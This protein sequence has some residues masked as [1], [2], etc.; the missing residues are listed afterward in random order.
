MDQVEGGR[1][2]A[3]NYAPYFDE[4]QHSLWMGCGARAL[5][6]GGISVVALATG[7]SRSRVSDGVAQ[8]RAGVTPLGQAR[9]AG[10]GTVP[11]ACQASNRADTNTVCPLRVSN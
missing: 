11:S 8:L 10:A 3:E 2:R 7:A 1:A 9:W 6:H 4:R 5:G